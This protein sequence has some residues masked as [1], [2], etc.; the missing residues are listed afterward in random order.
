ML[1]QL[2]VQV[3]NI[4]ATEQHPLAR[5][6]PSRNTGSYYPGSKK[7]S[8]TSSDTLVYHF[9]SCESVRLLGE[10]LSRDTFVMADGLMDG[11]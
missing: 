4:S 6:L 5:K 11:Q 10:L 8:P 3:S 7:Q 9:L 1:T 2:P